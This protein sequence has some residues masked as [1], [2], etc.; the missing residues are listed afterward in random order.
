M[1]YSV[2][3]LAPPCIAALDASTRKR[4]AS[5]VFNDVLDSGMDDERTEHS[6]SPPSRGIKY[7][8][9]CWVRGRPLEWGLLGLGTGLG[10]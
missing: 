3:R 4:D 1:L 6:G 2:Y 9:N 8:I 5:Q 10:L 7:A